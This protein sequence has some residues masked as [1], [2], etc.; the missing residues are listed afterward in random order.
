[1][2]DLNA[3]VANVKRARTITPGVLDAWRYLRWIYRFH[4]GRNV[5]R[6]ISFLLAPPVGSCSLEVRPNNGSDAFIFSEI[7]IHRYYDFLLP[8]EPQT[9]LDLGANIGL[10]TIFFGRKYPRAAICSVEP[11]LSN[12][13][14]LQRNVDRNGIHATVIGAAV[15]LEDGRITMQEAP[16]AYGH[17]IADIPFGARLDGIR[18]DVDALSMS[19]LLARLGWQT[20][21]LLKLDIEGY[22]AILLRERT[23]WI[24]RVRATF[25]REALP[26]HAASCT[27]RAPSLA[28]VQ[29]L[30]GLAAALAT[31]VSP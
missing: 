2:I 14:I 31:A 22:E 3:F 6:A 18:F 13:E 21:D 16:K 24:A 12:L 9:I 23:E 5:A 17:K 19:S 28:D 30:S 15:A 8:T 7:F 11:V 10:A 29:D 26:D 27:L 20:V 25:A 1:M 4:F